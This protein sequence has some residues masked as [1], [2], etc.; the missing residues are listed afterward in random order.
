MRNSEDA[1][2]IDVSLDLNNDIQH[3]APYSES[4]LVKTN[5]ILCRWLCR[6]VQLFS[7][8]SRKRLL[9]LFSRVFLRFMAALLQMGGGEGCI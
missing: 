6:T 1:Y 3:V 4:F 9:E 8:E 7:R 5:F 2:R